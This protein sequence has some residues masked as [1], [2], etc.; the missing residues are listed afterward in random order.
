M[1]AFTVL[2]PQCVATEVLTYTDKLGRTLR[3]QVPAHRVVALQLYEFLPAL[4]CWDRIAAVSR[5]A[6]AD[7]HVLAAKPDIART[8][9]AAG[10]GADLN[11]EALL[12]A[13][14]DLVITWTVQPDNVKFMEAQGLKVVAV[15]PE[16]T[17][18]M[19]A[20][21]EFL[22]HLYGR[23]SEAG[24]VSSEM[25][26]IFDLI[27]SRTGAIP[28]RE[29]Q[30][31]LYL[32]QSQN[33]V[34]GAAGLNNDIIR[35]FGASNVSGGIPQKTA[36]VSMETIVSWNPDVIFV[37]GYATFGVPDVLNNPQYRFV[38]AVREGR[39]YRLPRW[40]TWSPNLAPIALWMAKK[41]YPR[42]FQDIDIHV[43]T[44]RF[45][46]SVFGFPMIQSGRNDF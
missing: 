28:D 4:H 27:T 9:P 36:G 37:W 39:V 33:T 30:R 7:V 12:K 31:V 34:A 41:T 22:G 18:E 32:S 14:P 42:L 17:E 8:I 10:S 43:I 2:W 6:H 3:I 29:R 21:L 11:M 26:R 20:A 16:S 44:D 5:S 13:K 46:R 38:K 23:E 45:N 19:L 25:R 24:K 1:A 15:S 40:S 35:M